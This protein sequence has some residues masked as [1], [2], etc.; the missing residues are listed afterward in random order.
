VSWMIM[1]IW[2]PEGSSRPRRLCDSR[3]G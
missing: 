2:G 1:V 3:H